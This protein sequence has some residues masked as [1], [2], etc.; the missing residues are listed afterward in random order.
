MKKTLSLILFA[1]AVLAGCQKNLIE[2]QPQEDNSGE[3]V[4][5]VAYLD[6]VDAAK[7]SLVDD[8]KLAW[9]KGDQIKIGNNRVFTVDSVDANNPMRAFFTG[10]AP[11]TAASYRAF[12]PVQSYSSSA[13]R[14]I[15][16][17]TQS[18]GLDNK[19]TN[20]N[21]MYA[22]TTDYNEIHFHNVCG[23]LAIDLKGEGYVSN[24]RVSA[25]QYI[26]GTLN[27][28]SISETG[29]L[30]YT[31]WYSSMSSKP[32]QYVDLGC[33]KAA[34]LS[35]DAAR[36]FYIAVPEADYDNLKLVITT[37]KG[38]MA[39]PATKKASVKKNNIYHIPEITV[40]IKPLEF[41]AQI[42]VTKNTATATSLDF[43]ISVTPTDKNVYY[44]VDIQSPVYVG[45][46]DYAFAKEDVSYYSGATLSQLVQYGYAFKGDCAEYTRSGL[47]QDADYVAYAYAVDEYFNVSVPVK[48]T[49]HTAKGELPEC[50]AQYSDY[51]GEWTLGTDVIT[52]A[53]L[54]NG[55]TYKV[56]GISTM[57][58]AL[59][60]IPYVTANFEKGNFVLNEQYTGQKASVGSYG[61]CEFHLSGLSKGA[62]LPSYPFAVQNP[63]MILYGQYSSDKITVYSSY[64]SL[65]ISWLILSGTY[66]G[67]G[68]ILSPTTTIPTEMKHPETLPEA[69]LGQ[70]KV[71]DGY[72][73]RTKKDRT[74]WTLTL[75]Q[76]GMGVD[77]ANFDPR[78]A[79]I[80]GADYDIPR[81]IWDASAKTLTLAAGTETGY[82]IQWYGL[83]SDNYLEDIVFDVDLE[84]G[85]LSLANAAYIAYDGENT[86][87]WY[88]APLVF[89]K[90]VA[91]AAP[92]KTTTSAPKRNVDVVAKAYDGNLKR[93]M[94][95]LPVKVT[96]MKA[97]IA[98]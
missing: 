98:R 96:Y 58:N 22:V 28:M 57:T 51:I 89:N 27:G 4:T 44:I 41:D 53:E 20:V 87:S 76:N 10:T 16:P 14:F 40:D 30:T 34:T 91:P 78:L 9:V 61:E 33:G 47:A 46:G 38:T 82:G 77:I 11:T 52:V 70:W 13:G 93:N 71:A 23:L 55:K 15:L 50:S 60:T 64:A 29:A 73:D 95:N 94:P 18:Y 92:A 19:V 1:A 86:Y 67:N 84:K 49:V 6:D 39:V 35:K 83:D 79:E 26:S 36:R 54:E 31:G 69:L 43:A 32:A 2:A 48:L 7:L 42:T 5:I 85:T 72:I 21:Y 68:N 74:G 97:N 80:G 59:C 62:N 65:G 25:D 8:V 12:Y 3:Q 17:G 24:I 75:S 56:T 45:A 90:V 81:F 63:A 37:D 66:T 88:D